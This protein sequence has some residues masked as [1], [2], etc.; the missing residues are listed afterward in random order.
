MPFPDAAY[1]LDK[2]DKH[3][4]RQGEFGFATPEEYEAAGDAFMNAAHDPTAGLW[5]CT[6]RSDHSIVRYNPNTEEF[7]ILT[8]AGM[9]TAYY[10][11]DPAI[12]RKRS[13][14]E[15]FRMVCNS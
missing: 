9:L 12:H 1:R 7:G 3:V 15:Y 10:I 8:P 6:R 14:V 2:F 5:E 11:L 4:Q 13:N